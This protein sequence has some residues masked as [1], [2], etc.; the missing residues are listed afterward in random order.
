VPLENFYVAEEYHQNY[1]INNPNQAYCQIVIAP[2][3]E[4][5]KKV[6]EK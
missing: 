4:N 5:F 2:K 6:F 1:F 3:L